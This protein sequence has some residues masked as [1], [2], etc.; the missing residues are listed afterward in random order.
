MALGNYRACDLKDFHPDGTK[1]ARIFSIVSC[2]SS[3]H[4]N[5]KKHIQRV[6]I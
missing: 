2:A 6:I 1:V 4:T 3:G 5:L